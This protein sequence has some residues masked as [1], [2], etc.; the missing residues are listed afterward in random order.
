MCANNGI[1]FYETIVENIF[2]I[3]L[4]SRNLRQYDV[5][6]SRLEPGISWYLKVLMWF[7][8]ELYII[9]LIMV[10]VNNIQHI[11]GMAVSTHFRENNLNTLAFSRIQYI[12]HQTS[13]YFKHVET[14]KVLLTVAEKVQKNALICGSVR[15]V[16]SRYQG[17]GKVITITVTP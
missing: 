3:L 6:H 9:Y 16:I 8:K 13:S 1:K 5:I 2:W 15:C 11:D 12:K 14:L 10:G 17:Q 4:I 7:G